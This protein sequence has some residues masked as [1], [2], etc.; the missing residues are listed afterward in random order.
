MTGHRTTR[1]MRTTTT[2]AM[3]FAAVPAAAGK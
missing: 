2:L 1:T 3:P